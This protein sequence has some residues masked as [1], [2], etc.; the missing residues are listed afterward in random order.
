MSF[1]AGPRL[2]ASA[3]QGSPRV[4]FPVWTWVPTGVA[5]P[6]FELPVNEARPR[7]LVKIGFLFWGRKG[8]DE[9]YDDSEKHYC[10]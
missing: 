2:L 5:T 9:G 10:Q 8:L 1:H 3:V 6:D 7:P 4:Y